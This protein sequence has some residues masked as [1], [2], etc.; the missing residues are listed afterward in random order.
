MNEGEFIEEIKDVD[1][2]ILSTESLNK[3]VIDHAK[4]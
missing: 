4:N 1:G 2:V 3:N